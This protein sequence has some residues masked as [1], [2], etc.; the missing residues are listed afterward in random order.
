MSRYPVGYGTAMVSFAELKRRYAGN[1]EPEYARRLFAWLESK[2]GAVGIGG[3]SRP[4]PSNTSQ[5]SKLGRSFHQ[6]QTFAD[7]SR[8]FCAVDLVHVN[9]SG[10]KHRTIQW[11]E[12]PEQGS[13]EA[14][15]WGLHCNVQKP[16]EPWHIQPIELD[17]YGTWENH[18]RPRPKAGYTIPGNPGKLRQPKPV[19]GDLGNFVP[20]SSEYGLYPAKS[21][22][23]EVSRDSRPRPDDRVRYLQGVLT[24]QC[25]L[26]GIDIDGYFGDMT[27]GGVLAVQK[28]NGLAEHGRCDEATWAAIDAYA[29]R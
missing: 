17:G 25:H 16:E 14:T 20:E 19:G 5:A 11:S 23:G 26:A 9:S 21:G 4:N 10:G 18:G 24:N 28:W 15:R 3:A 1:M 27:E 13:A 29:S 7:G 6:I 2:D 8:Y 12:V 22:K